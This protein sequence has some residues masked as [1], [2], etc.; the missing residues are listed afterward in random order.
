MTRLL[1]GSIAAAIV[2]Y[3]LGFLLFAT[4]LSMLAY[5]SA[6]PEANL[7]IQAAL[8]AN[9]PATGTYIVPM[10]LDAA[11]MAAYEAGP[12]ATV[13]YN[14]GGFLTFS[15]GTMIGGFIHML[16]AALLFAFALG[17]IKDRT[18]LFADRARM[19]VLVAVSTSLYMHLGQPIWSH[20]GWPH[21]IYLFIAD[22]IIFASGGL[23][24]ARWFLPASEVAA[25]DPR[26]DGGI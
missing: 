8:K 24:L 25:R 12:I 22:A 18:P 16:L 1:V 6:T 17:A 15:P 11:G 7:A 10:P 23:V 21:F 4:P 5:G 19:V 9:L 20:L 2:M 14:S 26:L 13:H 3:I